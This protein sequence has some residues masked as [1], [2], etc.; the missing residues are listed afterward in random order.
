MKGFKT[1]LVAG[2]KPPYD[3]WTFVVIPAEL[4]AEW[5]TG[6]TAVRGTISGIP[7]RGAASRGQGQLRVPIPKKL[8]ERAGFAR[9][10]IV[11]VMIEPDTDPPPL[12]IPDELGAIFRDQPDVARLYEELP[13]SF[14]RAWATYVG[15][16]KRPETRARRAQKAPDGI[17]A[18]EFPR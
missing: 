13:P 9:G 1:T 3:S 4:A 14:R 2:S 7:F 16:A 15:D 10:D 11:E 17:R 6:R 12:R 8:R 18:R 5:G